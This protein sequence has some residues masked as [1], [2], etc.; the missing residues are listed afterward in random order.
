MLLVVGL[1]NPGSKYEATRHNVGFMVVDRLAE[2]A[3]VNRWEKRFK[4]LIGRGRLSG[5]DVLFAKPQTYMNLS[6]ESV[7]PMLGFYKLKTSDVVVVHDELDLPVGSLKLKKAGG[8]GGHNGLRN[9]KLHL[10]DD[11]FTRVRIGIG[12]PPPRWDPSDYV[13]S[14][15]APDELTA[16]AQAILDATDAVET[17]LKDGVSKAMNFYNR[18]DKALKAKREQQS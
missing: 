18:T 12:R 17:I 4:A 3:G 16:M 1:G 10:P 8:H 6:G 11:G 15:F 7:G 14:R 9:L 2:T 5:E 13:L